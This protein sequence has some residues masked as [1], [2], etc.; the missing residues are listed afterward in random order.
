MSLKAELNFPVATTRT[1]FSLVFLS[2][3]TNTSSVM[4]YFFALFPLKIKLLIQLVLSEKFRPKLHRHHG[5]K[6]FISIDAKIFIHLMINFLFIYCQFES[7]CCA[8]F[9]ILF[10][11][12]FIHTLKLTGFC[13]QSQ[14]VEYIDRR[15]KTQERKKVCKCNVYSCVQKHSIFFHLVLWLF[16]R[17]YFVSMAIRIWNFWGIPIELVSI[18]WFL[19]SIEFYKKNLKENH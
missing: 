11:P 7:M 9:H 18:R 8:L 10:I 19:V 5:T 3:I 15:D 12:F 17:L 6:Q 14:S 16:E 1:L 2:T 4:I 13:K